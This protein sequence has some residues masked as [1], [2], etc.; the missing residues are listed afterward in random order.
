[1]QVVIVGGGPAGLYAAVLLR[2]V[3]PEGDV[4]VLE[5]GRAGDGGTA[6]DGV[7]LAAQ[8]L[9]RL[10]AADPPTYDRIAQRFERWSDI[11]VH[12]HGRTVRSRGHDFVGIGRGTL[13]AI[14]AERADALGAEIRYGADLPAVALDG[15][16]DALG[17]GGADLVI[18]ADGA[19]SG[20]RA[21]LAEHFHPF[22]DER[23]SRHACF[24]TTRRFDASTFMFV[25]NEHGIIQAH[26]FPHD[27]RHS[28]FIVQCGVDA[29]RSA[30]LDAMNGEAAARAAEAL[31]APWLGG[32][33]L[34]P[35]TS[36]ETSPWRRFVDVT[37]DRWHH[38]NVVLLGDAA[39]TSH[40]AAGLAPRLA[41]EDALALVLA[42]ADGGIDDASL[43]SYAAERKAE[44]L[45][46]RRAAAGTME[47]FENV[48][49]YMRLPTEQF[50]YALV[51]R[52]QGLSHET[53]R[54]RDREFVETVEHSLASGLVTRGAGLTSSPDARVAEPE[55]RPVPPMFTPF[56]LREL[57]LHNRVVLAPMDLDCA[58]DGAPNDFHVAHFA[59][60]AL[61][62][63]GL[64]MTE[65]VAVAPDARLSPGNAGMYD[66]AHVA[67]WRRVVDAV[68]RWSPGKMCLQLGHAG[69]RGAVRR[70]WEGGAPLEN[71]AGWEIVAPS[72]VPYREGGR[73]P[74]AMTRADMESVRDEFVR[75]TR[76]A[77]DAGFDMLELQCAHGLLL[78][79][80]ITPLAN[81]RDDEYGG[82]LANRLR[83]PLEVFTAM[84]GAWPS[85]RPMSVCISASDWVPGG[86]DAT[87]G[88]SIARAFRD[89]GADI[90][91]V[92]AGHTAPEARLVYG[93][94]YLT[95][96]SDRVR[97]EAHVPTIAVGNITDANEV[98]AIIA[99]GRADLCALG[100]A[101]LTNPHWTLHAAAECGLE[102]QWWP[103]PYERGR[104]Q[105]EREL[106]RRVDMLEAGS[107]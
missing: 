77:V 62:G 84:R 94:M 44:M 15:A 43:A 14:L 75:G 79:S 74:R 67:A 80:F 36:A 17:L 90:V 13:R 10:R 27:E 59:A 32:E 96:L 98:N 38:G 53:L 6:A 25:E 45:R 72:P 81:K 2:L 18:A 8:S 93:R 51:T 31:I 21:Q 19:Q 83:F 101:L 42:L 69:A 57:T 39:H 7:A 70:L 63:A 47:W 64:L 29:W 22:L 82:S 65:S 35:D 88:V 54:R 24:A 3:D 85:E 4:V 28:T 60:R 33:S 34:I 30:G 16:L 92:S 103:A 91:H 102:S 68:H 5:R 49:R 55:A 1:M 48:G 89:A 61:G 95:P 73:V 105:L 100:R 97:N 86:V 20:V 56:R 23:P 26:A 46:L 11:V 41:M 78:S 58:D 9:A 52:T 40:F 107:L 106:Q 50:A 87:E 99:A 104:R 66:T 76:M 12:V 37:N 71:G